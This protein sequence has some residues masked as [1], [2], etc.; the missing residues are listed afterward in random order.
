[1]RRSQQICNV[2]AS[3]KQTQ[4]V[5]GRRQIGP[6]RPKNFT[7]VRTLTIEHL[8]QLRQPNQMVNSDVLEALCITLFSCNEKLVWLSTFRIPCRP[9]YNWARLKVHDGKYVKDIVTSTTRILIPVYH[10]FHYSLLDVNMGTGVIRHHDSLGLSGHL[11][12]R[13]SAEWYQMAKNMVQVIREKN[14][15]NNQPEM[16]VVDPYPL[17]WTQGQ[18]KDLGRNT[19]L[20]HV[21]HYIS[22]I[23]QHEDPRP[24]IDHEANTTKRHMMYEILMSPIPEPEI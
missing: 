18:D 2:A 4:Q 16:Q 6:E 9:D 19:C 1:M 12:T 24:L 20:I 11:S 17:L 3:K 5:T 14:G 21:F 7:R 10:K 15:W 8:W 23:V 22:T 13:E